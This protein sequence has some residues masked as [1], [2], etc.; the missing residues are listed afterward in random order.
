MKAL[1]RLKDPAWWEQR[2]MSFLL[3]LIAYFVVCSVVFVGY[4]LLQM[5]PQ[6]DW[7]TILT[8]A[9]GAFFFCVNW[10]LVDDTLWS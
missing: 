2:S 1:S 8:I 9:G 6:L 10:Y 7:D 3:T 5:L 4:T